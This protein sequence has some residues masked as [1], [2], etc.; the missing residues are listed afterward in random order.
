MFF[1]W[2]L[3][4]LMKNINGIFWYMNIW[5]VQNEMNELMN[6]GGEDNPIQEEIPEE[7]RQMEIMTQVLG[8]R[9]SGHVK[10]MGCGVIPTP[11]SSSRMYVFIHTAS[12]LWIHTNTTGGREEVR[13]NRE[14]ARRNPKWSPRDEH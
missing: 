3:F 13:R 12:Q 7:E 11:L 4:L 9:R 5:L 8:G 6:N 1:M 10:G 14:E 2:L